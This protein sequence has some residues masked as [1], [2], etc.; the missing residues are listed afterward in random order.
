VILPVSDPYY[1][2]LQE[3]PGQLV[4]RPSRRKRLVTVWLLVAFAC[5]CWSVGIYSLLRP[6][7]DV[8]GFIFFLLTGFL[9]VV[10]AGLVLILW[11][12]IVFDAQKQVIFKWQH[13]FGKLRMIDQMT[14][15][16]LEHIRLEITFGE[17][18]FTHIKLIGPS[19]KVW[20]TMPGYFIHNH[21]KKVRQ[22][23]LAFMQRVDDAPDPGEETMKPGG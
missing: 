12:E 23:L 19:N 17:Y 16:Q 6:V 2:L 18:Q 14:F 10:A 9:L 4:F 21:A 5:V 1:S 7:R 13:A 8:Q 20:A 22:K 11:T 3:T 15:Q